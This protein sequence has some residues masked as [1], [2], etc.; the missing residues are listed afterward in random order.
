MDDNSNEQLYRAILAALDC[1]N[2]HDMETF[3]QNFLQNGAVWDMLAEQ[4]PTAKP[5]DVRRA[6]TRAFE[7]F[8]INHSHHQH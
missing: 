4:F 7:T 8:Q 6:M 1:D 5:S 3:G 2:A